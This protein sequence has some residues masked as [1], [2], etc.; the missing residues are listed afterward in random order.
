MSILAI[1]G[2]CKTQRILEADYALMFNH[3]GRSYVVLN[4]D[5]WK[6]GGVLLNV[7]DDIVYQDWSDYI[8]SHK[9]ERPWQH[10]ETTIH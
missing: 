5:V 3:D 2:H 10:E 8:S 6:R 4:I 9:Y 7:V 1:N